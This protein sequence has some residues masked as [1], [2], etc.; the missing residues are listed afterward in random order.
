MAETSFLTPDGHTV[1]AVTAE[2]MRQVDEVAESR[3]GLGVLQTMEN[4]GRSLARHARELRAKAGG[5]GHVAV[6]AGGGDNGGGGLCAAR[7]LANH[8]VPVRVVLDRDPADLTGPAAAQA[9]TLG[10]TGVDLPA[11]TGGGAAPGVG[12][13]IAD[14]PVL[15]DA[16]VGY[17]PTEALRGPTADLAAACNRQDGRVLSNDVPSGVDATTGD[18]HGVVVRPDRTLTLALPKTGL[19]DLSGDL[20]LADV[21]IPAA[22]YRRVGVDYE[23]P[24]DGEYWVRLTGAV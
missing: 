20:W 21:G 8:G 7:H 23:S 11:A 12:A 17:G 14:A 5:H 6:L 3:F 1:P 24:F 18:R 22:V 9:R 2:E 13:A 4:A 16:L 15:V 10:E 19:V